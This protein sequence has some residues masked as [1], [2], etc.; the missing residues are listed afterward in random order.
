MQ[1]LLK[2]IAVCSEAEDVPSLELYRKWFPE[3]IH[4][5]EP[6]SYILN[7]SWCKPR[8]IVRL[9]TTAQN[10]L[11]N[12]DKAFT[13]GV[14]TSITKSYS[15]DSLQEIKEE[16][17]ALYTSEEI[18]CIVGCFT[19]YRTSFSVSD[20]QKRVQ[21]YFQGTIMQTKFVQVLNDLYRL[22]FIG[23]FLPASKTYHWHHK[24]DSSL[25]MAEEWRLCIHYALHG[26]LSIGSKNDYGLNRG[27]NPQTGD[28]VDA[29]VKKIIGHFALVDFQFYGKNYSGSLHV[30]EFR[31]IHPKYIK[32]LSDVVFEG[33]VYNVILDKYDA[34]YLRWRLKLN[35]NITIS[36]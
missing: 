8:D 12:R 16:M 33:E 26:A 6:A 10:S 5:I 1:I 30:S 19:G 28:V 23:N 2:R 11:H 25:I 17:R 15:E 14:F 7:N 29:I 3:S 9:I 35:D 18:D 20:L 21:Q 27:R 13:M 32:N 4:N 24:G 31:K 34:Q 22:G 36:V